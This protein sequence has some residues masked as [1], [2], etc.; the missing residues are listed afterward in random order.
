MHHGGAKQCNGTLALVLDPSILVNSTDMSWQ[1][2]CLPLK[3]YVV[4]DVNDQVV[5]SCQCRRMLAMAP[6]SHADNG[7]VEAMLVVV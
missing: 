3:S 6:L 2:Y 4:V 5:A 1:R 7:V